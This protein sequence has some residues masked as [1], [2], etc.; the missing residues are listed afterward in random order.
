MREASIFRTLA[1]RCLGVLWGAGGA[2]GIFLLLC[3]AGVVEPD[4]LTSPEPEPAV[5]AAAWT[6]PE[7]KPF[8]AAFLEPEDLGRAVHAAK[9]KDGVVVTMKGPDGKLAWVS[10]LPQAADSEASWPFPARNEAI[11]TMNDTQELYTVARISCLR[12]TPLAKTYPSLALK[13][14]SGS[15]WRDKDGH[16]WLDPSEPGVLS[17]C[18]GLCRE[19][20]ELGFDEILLTDCAFPTGEGTEDLMLPADPAVVL[21]RFCRQ[22]QKKLADC[23]VLLSIEGVMKDGKLDPESGQTPALL[24]SFSGRVWAEESDSNALA[25]FSPSPIP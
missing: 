9:G 8:R 25:V 1:G 22:L 20:A 18:S 24:A 23:P 13:R 4:S 15:L 19:L 16:C 12:D 6:A 14:F 7:H 10:A 5:T 2:A 21:D 17:W 11:R 3:A